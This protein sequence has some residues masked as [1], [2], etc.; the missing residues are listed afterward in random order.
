M[1]ISLHVSWS[2]DEYLLNLQSGNYKGPRM[3][4]LLDVDIS[5]L[6]LYLHVRMHSTSRFTLGALTLSLW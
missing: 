1:R 4:S 6:D 3:F 2:Q 5:Y